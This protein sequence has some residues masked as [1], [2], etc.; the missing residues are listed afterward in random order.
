MCGHCAKSLFLPEC[1]RNV[2]LVARLPIFPLGRPLVPGAP[3]ALRVFEPRY[4]ELIDDLRSVPL[5][6]RVFGVVLIARGLEV[7]DEAPS[8]TRTGCVA[9]VE[10]VKVLAREPWLQLGVQSVGTRRFRLGPVDQNTGS[11]AVADV[12]WLEDD[13]SDPAALGAEAAGLAAEHAAYRRR[14]GAEE[15]TFHGAPE[16]YV[17][18]AVEEMVL[19]PRDIQGLLDLEDPLVRIR[20]LRELLRR[21]GA[22]GRRFATIPHV[23]RPTGASLN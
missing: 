13:V 19:A 6:Q 12:T 9:L 22:I 1:A 18:Q 10:D 15:V 23:E 4:L 20:R 14:L 21:E 16:T 17:W 5:A 2:G 11:Y 7:G 8:L 3:L